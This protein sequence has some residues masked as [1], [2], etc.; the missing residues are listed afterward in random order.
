MATNDHFTPYR[1]K[2]SWQHKLDHMPMF[3]FSYKDIHD[4]YLLYLSLSHWQQTWQLT[5]IFLFLLPFIT[6]IFYHHWRLHR[7]FPLQKRRRRHPHRTIIHRLRRFRKSRRPNLKTHHAAEN[8]TAGVDRRSGEGIENHRDVGDH[9]AGSPGVVYSD[10]DGGSG[11]GAWG[12]GVVY[13]GGEQ[14]R[15]W[16]NLERMSLWTIC[17]DPRWEMIQRIL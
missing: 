5:C 10:V 1:I 3:F 13:S 4:P 2:Y 8:D 11:G 9:R 6:F 16:A 15:W 12:C 7:L 17:L 14:W